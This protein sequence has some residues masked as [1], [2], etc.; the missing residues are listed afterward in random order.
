MDTQETPNDYF[1]WGIDNSA[2]GPV[3]LS[4]LQDWIK[5]ERVLLETWIF[6]SRDGTWQRASAVAELKDSFKSA[7]ES[8]TETSAAVSFKPGTLRRIKILADLKDAQLAHLA[9]FLEFK[10]ITHHAEWPS[11]AILATPCISS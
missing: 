3:S 11:K 8:I 4:V 7:A 10:K 5:D 6:A 9:D 1:I 2:Y